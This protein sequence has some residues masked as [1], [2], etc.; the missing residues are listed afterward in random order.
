MPGIAARGWG[1][2]PM[3]PIYILNGP[4]LSRLDG[5]TPDIE[6]AGLAEVEVMSRAEAGTVPLVFRQSNSEGDIVGWIQE[7]IHE[8]AAIIINPAAFTFTSLAVP[9]ALQRFPGPV[10]ELHLTNIFRHEP[11]RHH[12]LISQTATAVIA[13]LG[14]DGYPAAVRAVRGMLAARGAPQSQ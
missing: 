11:V 8:A 1:K 12:S 7:A 6:S 9:D 13:G 5:H 10:I 14:R 3:K 2:L 4:G